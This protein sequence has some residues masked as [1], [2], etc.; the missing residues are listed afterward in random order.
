MKT[1]SKNVDGSYVPEFHFG[2]GGCAEEL[3][4]HTSRYYAYTEA[5]LRNLA[6]QRQLSLADYQASRLS[7]AQRRL[8]AAVLSCAPGRTTA[9]DL[10]T[11]IRAV[12]N[13]E[14][15]VSEEVTAR[16]RDHLKVIPRDVGLVFAERPHRPDLR[17][18]APLDPFLN[19]ARRLNLP[20][21]VR[22]HHV[23]VSLKGL[24][25]HLDSANATLRSN[26][27]EAILHVHNAGYILRNHPGLTHKTAK[28][29]GDEDAV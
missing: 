29:I 27:Q 1:T 3:F 4:H 10:T 9:R 24:A 5:F 15:S 16:Y 25:Q 17:N 21:A 26:L 18:V 8:M 7:E 22:E 11:I 23:E 19:L 2:W 20:V 14:S 28:T 6:D 13:G 12:N